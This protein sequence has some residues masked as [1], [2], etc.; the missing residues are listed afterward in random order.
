MSRKAI[1]IITRMTGGIMHV[2]AADLGQAC[3]EIAI[4]E[5]SDTGMAD[6]DIT[7]ILGFRYS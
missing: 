5:R 1:T 2:H 6:E 3:P 7:Q 4:P